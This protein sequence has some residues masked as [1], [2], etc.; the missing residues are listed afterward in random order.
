MLNVVKHLTKI[1][2]VDRPFRNIELINMLQFTYFMLKKILKK[3][4]IFITFP[5][6]VCSSFVSIGP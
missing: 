1:D 4:L 5:I 3:G 6:P 2:W